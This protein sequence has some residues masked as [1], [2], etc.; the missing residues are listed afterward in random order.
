MTMNTMKKQLINLVTIIFLLMSF[1]SS[2]AA[3]LSA[4]IDRNPVMEN[5]SFILQ[6]VANDS[7]DS[8]AL[9]LSPLYQAGFVVGRNSTSSQTQIINGSI[10]KTTTWSV[11]LLARKQGNYTI[12]ALS[13][14]G[15]SSKPITVK[16]IKSSAQTGQQSQPIFLKNSI[17]Q[18]ELYLQQSVKLVTRLYF[19][20]NIDLQSGTLS[21][22]SLEGA[23][24]KQQGK[25]RDTSEIIMG[26]RY[27][28]IER[29]YTVT[30][31]AS[32]TFTISSPSFNGEISSDRRRNMYSSFGNRKP[33]SSIGNDIEISVSPIPKSYS[34]S[35]IPSDLVQ[36]NDEWQ[37]KQDSYEV[38]EPITR[39]FTLTALNVNEEQLPEVV[40]QYPDSFNKYPDQSE[41]H[42]V[43]RQNA[44]V[45]QRV[46]SEAIVATQAGS[47]TLPAVSVNWFNTKT[48]RQEVAQI[49]AKTITITA[50][51]S[52]KQNTL[53]TNVP[54]Q[55]SQLDNMNAPNC[56]EV[57]PT[58]SS[59]AELFADKTEEEAKF[60]WILTL[61]GWIVW[62]V[63]LL[64]FFIFGRKYKRL[65]TQIEK[66]TNRVATKTFEVKNLKAACNN[67]DVRA[68]RIELIK[69]GQHTFNPQLNTLTALM[70]LVDEA[71]AEQIKL[72]NAS[73][74][75][76]L[77]QQWVGGELWSCF[78]N[79]SLNKGV[80][81]S[82]GLPPLNG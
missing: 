68:C 55:Q 33:I 72:L 15:V 25:D 16:V 6:I 62:L 79:Q 2:S 28:V 65:N 73:Q 30:P 5:E 34:G 59:C 67:N 81:I 78:K 18:T 47:F 51:S 43:I 41:A 40:G 60:A 56:P 11:V 24:V 35:W 21:D 82:N 63:T 31:Q 37:P 42:S 58:E 71:L 45:S 80:K 10:S 53:V 27:R 52:N 3:E 54:L 26:V 17:E 7:I 50:P 38:G 48:Q 4:S 69:W 29:I 39:T 9:D 57:I 1:S 19:A 46:S 76:K 64:L 20:P 36:L 14:E 66:T 12:P 22:P 32:G 61:S 74:Y 44:I 23:T 75:S 8:D 49:P 70:P 77:P 13:A